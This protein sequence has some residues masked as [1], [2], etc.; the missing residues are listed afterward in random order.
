MR[1]TINREEFLKGLNIAG[2]A[3]SSKT[4]LPIY[5]NLK[6]ELDEEGLSITGSNK[7][8][9]I[10][11]LVPIRIGEN[12]IIRNYKEGGTLINAKI[13]I[14]IARE[15]EE[16]EITFDV[17]DTTVATISN[18][19]S[20]YK[21]NCIKIEE[22]PDLDL[23]AEGTSLTMT[24]ADFDLLVDQTAFAASTKDQRPILTA[25]N[26]EADEGLLT[27]TATD[28]ARLARKVMS[29][30]A[31]VKFNVSVPARMMVEVA[32]LADMVP[33][34]D[35]AVSDKK[36]LFTFG[37]TVIATSL[38]AGDY[39]NTKNIVPRSF[40][41]TL[42]VN[43]QELAK[44]ITR[45]RLLSLD[46]ENV[47]ELSMSDGEVTVSARASQV[48]SANEHISVFNYDGEDLKVSFNSEFVVSAIRALD[49]EDVLF[50][51]VGE[52]KPFVIKNPN[53]ES[54]V[55]V[56]TPVRTY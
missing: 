22:Y 50:L 15:M 49:S 32:R 26:L 47:V 36:I 12:E 13:I 42:Q 55:Q 14:D 52:M 19:R 40:G 16:E 23:D 25:I 43:A 34:I 17:I 54:V 38:I 56:V 30:P 33:S 48:G 4:P 3:I 46:R 27:A 28:S 18:A 45:A 2:R 37:R 1:F 10:K 7:E 29:V 8:L 5:S 39:P 24:T 41:Y 21:L 44:S 35:I 51:F 9:S 11:T 6:L 20:E 53:D 31:D